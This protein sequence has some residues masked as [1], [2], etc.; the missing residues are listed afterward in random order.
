MLL[1]LFTVHAALA[2]ATRTSRKLRKPPRNAN[3]KHEASKSEN[4]DSNSDSNTQYTIVD[5]PIVITG[6]HHCPVKD[7]LCSTGSQVT[8]SRKSGPF[9]TSHQVL[10]GQLCHGQ[11]GLCGRTA[12]VRGQDYIVHGQEGMVSR[13]WLWVSDVKPCSCQ[14]KIIKK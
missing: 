2:L 11:P 13:E 5:Q 4:R 12:T 10:D 7:M 6:W 3:T 1:C 8:W 9:N 14:Q